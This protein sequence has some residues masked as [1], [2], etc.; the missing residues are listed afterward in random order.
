VAAERQRKA[1]TADSRTKDEEETRRR[2][3]PAIAGFSAGRSGKIRTCDPHV[4][5]V[6]R[7]QTA[8]HSVTSGASIEQQFSADKHLV[9]KLRQELRGCLPTTF[10]EP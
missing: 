7:Y 4:P 6:V 10:G 8:L 1:C 5:N 2:K 9:K 3:K